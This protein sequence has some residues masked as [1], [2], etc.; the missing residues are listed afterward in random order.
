VLLVGYMG[1]P[2]NW[3]RV[4]GGA[5]GLRDEV[6]K[7]TSCEWSTS[8]VS[9]AFLRRFTSLKLPQHFWLINS[10]NTAAAVAR[11]ESYTCGGSTGHNVHMST[12]FQININ[13]TAAALIHA[14]GQLRIRNPPA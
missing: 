1:R 7:H 8:F 10:A 14:T 11:C 4:T 9:S 5:E 6:D 3:T 13:I 12:Q 2:R